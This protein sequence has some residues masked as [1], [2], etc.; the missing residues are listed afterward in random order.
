MQ[1]TS[2][3]GAV[4]VVDVKLS[5]NLASLTIEQVIGKRKKL[6]R[7]AAE[8]A[9]IEART[10]MLAK[11][12]AE[13]ASAAEE[14]VRLATD[15]LLDMHG[16]EWFND[17]ANLSWA[18]DRVVKI[19]AAVLGALALRVEDTDQ[20]GQPIVREPKEG[21]EGLRI[22]EKLSLIHI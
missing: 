10:A 17:D 5:V 6:V 8:G 11:G 21:E 20:Y 12:S 16:A 13:D 2:V 18:V 14:S 19:K 22:L 1:D 15:R 9:R 3:E 7:D 4:L